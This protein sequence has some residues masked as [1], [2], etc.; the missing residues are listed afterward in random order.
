MKKGL[1]AISILAVFGLVFSCGDSDSKK[2]VAPSFTYGGTQAPGDYW[3][4]VINWDSAAE[5]TFSATNYGTSAGKTASFTYSG[6]ASLLNTKFTKFVIEETTDSSVAIGDAFYGVEIPGTAVLIQTAGTSPDFIT[7]SV[8]GTVPTDSAKYNW[9]RIP[10]A[11]TMDNHTTTSGVVSYGTSEI[12]LVSG[13]TYQSADNVYDWDKG[14]VDSST[15][16]MILSDSKLF[17]PD[18]SNPSCVTVMAP[19][20]CFVSDM[21]TDGGFFGSIA[22]SSDIS[23]D[24]LVSHDFRGYCTIYNSSASADVYPIY[25]KPSTT[26]KRML[27]ASYADVEAGTVAASGECEVNFDAAGQSSPGLLF[28]VSSINPSPGFEESIVTAV[29][30]VGEK[31]VFSGFGRVKFGTGEPYRWENFIMVQ[32][33]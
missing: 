24:D 7:C 8:I 17:S 19:S 12:S 15:T 18:L 20:G 11:A 5:G 16:P 2:A 29:A 6:T 22:P 31:Y 21:G 27:S 23:I 10:D 14:V 33:D 28:N 25:C 1:L 4:W 3:E 30:K 32:V 26:A 13:T 9:T